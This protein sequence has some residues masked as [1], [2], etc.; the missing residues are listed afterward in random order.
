MNTI[1][2][3]TMETISTPE[4]ARRVGVARATLQSYIEKGIVPFEDV[5]RYPDEN[6]KRYKLSKQL[7]DD[8]VAK[9]WELALAEYNKERSDG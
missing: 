2:V 7:A 5:V 9:G 3:A 1:E 8:I 4:F 6:R